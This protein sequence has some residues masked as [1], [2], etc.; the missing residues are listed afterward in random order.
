M[1][2]ILTG[3]RSFGSL[4]ACAGALVAVCTAA[5][6]NKVPLLAPSGTTITLGTSSTIVQSNGTAQVTATLLESSGTP[7]QNG[8]S[9]TFSTNLGRLTPIE[10]RTT[11]G[12]ATATFQASGSSGVAE[13]RA[14]SGAAKPADTANPALKITVGAA[15]AGRLAL[16]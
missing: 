13:I 2:S 7:V 11:N 8:T 9:V 6:C 5:G 3:P 10:A 4:L 16:S 12:V 15:A 1:F 14:V